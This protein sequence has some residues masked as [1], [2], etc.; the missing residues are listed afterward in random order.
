MARPFTATDDDIL[1]AAAKVMQRRGPDAF[2][3]AE[4]AAE[5][6]LSR[7]AIILRFKSTHDLKV[8]LLTKMVE[9]FAEALA[10]L[11]QS[12]SGDNLLR[13]AAF[14][15]NHVGSREGSAKYFANYFTTNARDRELFELER[16]RGEVLRQ[17]ISKVMPQVVID[18]DSAVTAFRSHLSG[19]IIAWLGNDE[20]DSCRHVVLRTREWLR[21]AGI[22]FSEELVE[23]LS[24]PK[25]ARTRKRA[26]P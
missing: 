2:A 1:R 19:S 5:V 3:M 9:R 4:V 15:G 23:E 25:T 17:A 24:A 11:P 20:P 6:G 7:A 26:S 10:A 14:I 22:A 8:T 12:P 13:V 18:H 21:L 16:L